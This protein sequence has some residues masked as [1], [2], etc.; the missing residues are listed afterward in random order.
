MIARKA[1][2]ED[3][4]GKDKRK[5]KL[6]WY[7]AAGI[8]AAFVL[9][10]AY[11]ASGGTFSFSSSDHSPINEADVVIHLHSTLSIIVNGKAMAV[12]ANIGIDP[13]LHR[14]HDLDIYGSKNPAMSPLHTHDS[15]GVIHVESTA[16]RSYTIGEF[17]DVW[18]IPFS[19][20]CFMD[21]CDDGTWVRI[22]V[23]GKESNEFG[24]HILAD[25]EMIEIIVTQRDQV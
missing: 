2:G 18:G 4:E 6:N 21:M 19:E 22:W 20:T 14:N 13:M 3:V 8:A 5:S 11:G 24:Q 12:P 25:G 10:I 17:F 1:L 23:N 15:S 16:V 9:G 7:I